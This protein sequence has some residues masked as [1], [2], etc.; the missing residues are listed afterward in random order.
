MK[1]ETWIDDYVKLYTM[2]GRSLSKDNI[3]K[4]KLLKFK[5]MPERFYKY[6]SF[7]ERGYSIKNLKEDT[8]WMTTPNKYNDPYDCTLRV[9][10]TENQIKNIKREMIE[11]F[12]K[13][14]GLKLTSEE[15]RKLNEID[16]LNSFITYLLKKHLVCSGEK[17]DI[18]ELNNAINKEFDIIN[19]KL[20][21]HFQKST[22]SCSFSEVNDSI[23][24]WSHYSYNHTGF[25]IEYNFKQL[26]EQ[27]EFTR[28]LLPVIY[29]DE[30]FDMTPFM[31]DKEE[32]NCLMASYVSMN[33]STEWQYEKEWRYSIPWGPG[34]EPFA[35]GVPTPTAIYLG[36][37]ISSENEKAI[38][39]IAQEKSIEVY[40]MKME[41]D[42]FKLIPER[43]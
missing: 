40:K 14:R 27:H 24:M 33:K 4:A 11:N 26:D 34:A 32:Y 6:R 3:D 13:N 22:L 42:E 12:K 19:E 1:K 7:D 9:R 43:I 17:Y 5:H 39:E 30:L 37:K 35:K 28:M 18:E 31:E 20:R 38:I 15:E 21:E 8:I 29:R 23:L 25:C 2:D 16:N 36:T 41:S 10:F